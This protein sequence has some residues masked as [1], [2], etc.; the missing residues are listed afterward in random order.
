MDFVLKNLRVLREN[1]DIN[2]YFIKYEVINLIKS[3][4]SSEEG[5][6]LGKV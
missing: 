3:L 6:W 2:K 4:F 1:M 5:R